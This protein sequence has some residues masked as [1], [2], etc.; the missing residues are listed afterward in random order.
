MEKENPT[1]LQAKEN[2]SADGML[3]A[4][5]P[6][7]VERHILRIQAGQMLN[8]A[9]IFQTACGRKGDHDHNKSSAN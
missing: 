7:S 3:F 9:E 2:K 6:L 5:N 1:A 8:A 4:I